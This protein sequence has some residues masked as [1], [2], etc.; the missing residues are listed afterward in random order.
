MATLAKA[1]PDIDYFRVQFLL[2]QNYDIDNPKAVPA[3]QDLVNK[4]G[5]FNSLAYYSYH[6]GDD[7]S[8][9]LTGDRAK[10]HL[11]RLMSRPKTSPA[12]LEGAA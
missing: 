2:D 1:S 9:P 7:P 3:L 6:C 8:K 11:L 5:V 4:A 12:D 10:E